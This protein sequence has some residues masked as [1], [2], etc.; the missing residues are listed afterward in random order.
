MIKRASV[1]LAALAVAAQ[2]AVASDDI[3]IWF[4]NPDSSLPSP[5]SHDTSKRIDAALYDFI[6]SAQSGTTVYV[7][8]FEMNLDGSGDA[9]ALKN[10]KGLLNSKS[11]D[12]VAIYVVGHSTVTLA[13]LTFPTTVYRA[14]YEGEGTEGSGGL[15]HNKFVVLKDSAVWTGSYNF[16]LSATLQQD[17][18]AAEI[19]SPE[20]AG[21][22]ETEFINMYGPLAV[23]S[24]K[25]GD[26]KTSSASA[27]GT[28]VNGSS[29]TMRDGT[30][31]K[32]YFNPYTTPQTVAAAIESEIAPS[33]VSGIP[34]PAESVGF[35]AAW[36]SR[37]SIS[38]AMKEALAADAG[39][40]ISGI[41]DD[42]SSNTSNFWSL[43]TSTIN[44]VW[45]S[46]RSSFGRGLMH[47]K[48]IFIDPR[49]LNGRVVTGSANWSNSGATS[50]GNDNDENIVIIYN[51]SVSGKYYDEF[52]R[53][54][55]L[56]GQVSAGAV[57]KAVD[58]V[59]M[60]PS[61]ARA[62]AAIGF[63]ISAVVEKI[64]IKIYTLSGELAR[65]ITPETYYPG[66][67]NEVVWNLKNS[68]GQRV[69]PGLYFIKVEAET[70]DGKFF[71]LK[72]AAV[73]K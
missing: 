29:V 72:K 16:T 35:A 59:I 26:I 54:F 23:A 18:N 14:A 60:Y 73:G 4:S 27:A 1:I 47:H 13:G 41:M 68:T 38:E 65:S 64:T 46:R 24:K 39:L 31:V 32:V 66:F 50:D 49:R 67:Y 3:K 2:I 20:L 22:F 12:G 43:K 30:V 8:I 57:A 15:M 37:T 69:A 45:D 63:D 33:P 28:N 44:V 10:I 7:A 11:A 9:S 53:M 55:A 70:P 58:N 56:T 48:F 36:F 62:S 51:S 71:A 25:F 52:R 19:F 21:V 5:L 42:Q 17:N 34:A 40:D 61:P 6:D